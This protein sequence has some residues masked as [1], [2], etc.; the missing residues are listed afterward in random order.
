MTAAY[1][2][3]DLPKAVVDPLKFRDQKRYS[4]RLR[5]ARETTK[6]DDALL[7]AHGT[8]GGTPR[9]GGGDVLRVHG[10][11]DGRCRRR[12]AGR[13]GAAGRAAGRTA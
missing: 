9:R 3:I 7:V 1:T 8:I 12:W 11:L 5:D 4:D 10:R 13:R 6:Q 2:R